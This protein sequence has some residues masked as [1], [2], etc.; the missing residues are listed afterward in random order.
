MSSST[1]ALFARFVTRR[2]R[3]SLPVIYESKT[4]RIAVLPLLALYFS[5]VFLFEIDSA[6][7]F[8]LGFALNTS[9]LGEFRLL[10]EMFFWWFGTG[11]LSSVGLGTGMHTGVLF[12]FPHIF[13]VRTSLYPHPAYTRKHFFRVFLTLLSRI[14]RRH[15]NRW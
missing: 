3:E 9:L 6:P 10:F 13:R 14:H 12:L 7:D 15:T 5:T 11:V 8:S 1:P 4:F 2:A